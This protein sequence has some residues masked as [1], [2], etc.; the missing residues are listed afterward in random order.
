MKNYVSLVGHLGKP[1]EMKPIN[2]TH[3]CKFSIAVNEVVKKEKV[4]NWFNI[5]VWGKVAENCGKYLSKGS[6]VKVDGRLD[7][8]SYENKDGEKKTAVEIVAS[9]VDFLQ[10]GEK[11]AQTDDYQSSNSKPQE[12]M[13][14]PF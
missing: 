13:E 14:I 5:V 2:D 1:P 9:S 3:L 10:T 11:K 6:L 8:R 4:T 7:I 12:E